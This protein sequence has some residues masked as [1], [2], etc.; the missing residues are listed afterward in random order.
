MLRL[1]HR[2]V[3]HLLVV[4]PRRV[5]VVDLSTSRDGTIIVAVQ[6]WIAVLVGKEVVAVIL[7]VV[8]WMSTLS[9]RQGQDVT[10]EGSIAESI[11]DN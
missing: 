7:R 8:T 9:T 4:L 10:H 11:Q 3:R 5:L 2:A 1:G 6:V